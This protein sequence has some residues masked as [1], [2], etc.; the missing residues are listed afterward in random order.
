MIGI[1]H[2]RKMAPE[3]TA[4]DRQTLV[5]L[6]PLAR[7]QAQVGRWPLREVR[8]PATEEEGARMTD[9]EMTKLC[10]E[11]MGYIPMESPSAVLTVID[12][13]REFAYSPLHSDAQAMVLVKKF[14]LNIGQLSGGAIQVFTAFDAGH[15]YQS[16]G[17]DLNRAIVETIANMM[18][19]RP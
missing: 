13:S 6:H 16:D 4:H 12:G 9:L 11:A 14:K 5:P 2:H 18:K 8:S 17:T 3:R 7:R 15:I 19:E 10:A 1:T